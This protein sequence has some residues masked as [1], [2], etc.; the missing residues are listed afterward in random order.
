MHELKVDDLGESAIVNEYQNL[1]LQAE[2]EEIKTRVQ[3]KK[4]TKAGR[5]KQKLLKMKMTER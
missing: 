5:K 3:A 4:P 1:S 2:A